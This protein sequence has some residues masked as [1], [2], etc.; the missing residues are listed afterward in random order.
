[1]HGRLL[2]LGVMMSLLSA[3]MPIQAPNA[4]T[5]AASATALSIEPSVDE[6]TVVAEELLGKVDFA[7]DCT[8][9]AQAEFNHAVAGL[10]SFWFAPA[11]ES[12]NAVLALDPAC[13]MADWGLAMSQMG[14]PFTWPLSGQPLVDGLAAAEQGL[15]LG[16][17]NEREAAYLDA[18]AT[19][20]RDSETV[21]HRTRALAYTDAMAKLAAAYPD[22]AEAQVYYALALLG[23]AL[24]TDK[25]YANQ[26][27]AVEILEQV[28]QANEDHPGVTH[29][30]IHAN[31]YP[32]LAAAGLDAARAYA[33]IAP[34]APHAV[35]MPSHI[36]TRVGHWQESV[37]TNR[38][39]AD[40]AREE[41]SATHVQGASSFN[42]LH[43]MDYLMYGY[44]QLGQDAKAAALLDE[45]AAIEALDVTNFVAAY[46][47][48]AIPARYILERGAWDKAAELTLPLPDM[49]WERF[50]QAEAIMVFARGLG[51]ARA[52]DVDAARS[53]LARL[54]EL[55]AAMLEVNQPYF[56]GQADIQM[57]E[58]EAWI[59]LAE[60]DAGQALTL[61]REA[62]ALEDETEKHPVTPGPFA[63]AH[64][65]LG[66]KLLEQDQPDEA[67]AEFEAS[68]AI[69]PNRFRG[70]YLAGRAAELAGDAERARTYY[71]GLVA[72]ATEADTER[73]ELAAARQFLSK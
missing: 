39:S 55:R 27:L 63:P 41:L 21:D 35:H 20:Y 19:F 67:L 64:E 22:D 56:A 48:T 34:D 61:M 53:E 50:P 7:V 8:A 12:F 5:S 30:L 38:R 6:H 71:D 36:F 18:V 40:A 70:W 24:P 65:M 33:D 58:V 44:L 57:R 47:L 31:D 15:A 29:Y 26:L 46:A 14:N 59:A 11:I 9:E 52:G 73:P 25:T 45:V 32:D 60:G 54:E 68:Q 72:L 17:K 23:T 49:V 69:E 37:D 13:A 43:A 16:P 4:E 62:V 66:E 2:A 1:M 28:G 42:A 51:A 10:H 3:C